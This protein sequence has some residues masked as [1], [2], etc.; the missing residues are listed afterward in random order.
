MEKMV[1]CLLQEVLTQGLFELEIR[2]RPGA[3]QMFSRVRQRFQSALVLLFFAG[4]EYG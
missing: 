2:M 4:P 1:R 3:L